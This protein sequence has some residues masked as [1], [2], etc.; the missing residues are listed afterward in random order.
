MC[1]HGEVSPLL[2]PPHLLSQFSIPSYVALLDIVI[3]IVAEQIVSCSRTRCELWQETI[4][5][6]VRRKGGS[7]LCS[8]H[9][10]GS[11]AFGGSQCGWRSYL[12]TTKISSCHNMHVHMQWCRFDLATILRINFGTS[13]FLFDACIRKGTGTASKAKRSHGARSC[14]QAPAGRRRRSTFHRPFFA[15][16]PWLES[17]PCLRR[18]CLDSASREQG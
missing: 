3:S 7:A 14:K 13:C 6:V 1:P 18:T 12:A 9:E 16:Y 4:S 2:E 10:R 17:L 5:V 11:A 15:R 8:L